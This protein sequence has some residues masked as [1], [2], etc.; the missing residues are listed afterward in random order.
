MLLGTG[1]RVA[2]QALAPG[3]VPAPGACALPLGPPSHRCSLLA[4]KFL[5]SLLQLFLVLPGV[6]YRLRK[7]ADIAADVVAHVTASQPLHTFAG[8]I[9]RMDAD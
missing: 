1:A 9:L 7:A 4:S 6:G 3:V 2:E 5:H 8:T